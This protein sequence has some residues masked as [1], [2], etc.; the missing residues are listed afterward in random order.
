MRNPP[1][2]PSRSQEA[3]WGL[4]EIVKRSIRDRPRRRRV[5][6]PDQYLEWEYEVIKLNWAQVKKRK[7]VEA[8]FALAIVKRLNQLDELSNEWPQSSGIE[9]VISEEDVL[10]VRA[11]IVDEIKELMA[12]LPE[13]HPRIAASFEKKVLSRIDKEIGK[14]T[15]E[16]VNELAKHMLSRGFPF[17]VVRA[18]LKVGS[19]RLRGRPVSKRRLAIRVLEAKIASPEL[20]WARLAWRFCDCGQKR[21]GF[22]CREAIRKSVGQLKKLIA[23]Y[24]IVLPPHGN[25]SS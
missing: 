8:A 11:E 24:H 15:K 1:D 10:A 17:D 14:P 12:W 2:T 20:S 19:P 18:V 7:P 6:F 4:E 23:K 21:H 16:E 9:R 13:T 3:D 22:T 25:K 5:P